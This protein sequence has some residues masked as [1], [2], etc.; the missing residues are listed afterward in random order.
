MFFYLA[1]HSIFLK[2][3]HIL[4]GVIIM[5]YLKI[6]NYHINYYDYTSL[7]WEFMDLT[8]KLV[9]TYPFKWYT[10]MKKIINEPKITY[11]KDTTMIVSLLHLEFSQ[12]KMLFEILKEYL[13][14][15]LIKKIIYKKEFII[16]HFH[17]LRTKEVMETPNLWQAINYYYTIKEAFPEMSVYLRGVIGNQEQVENVDLIVTSQ[18]KTYLI[19]SSKPLLFDTMGK[20]FKGFL[21]TELSRFTKIAPDTGKIRYAF[22]EN[23]QVKSLESF[24]RKVGIVSFS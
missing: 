5:K 19:N 9:K 23:S 22:D 13:K 7:D 11:F 15:R 12:I 8:N 3:F 6:D 21:F 4:E 20:C 18:D 16:V 24:F 10:L 2:S 1:V 17:S 14:V